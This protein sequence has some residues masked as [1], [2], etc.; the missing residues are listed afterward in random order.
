MIVCSKTVNGIQTVQFDSS[1]IKF[2]SYDAQRKILAVTFASNHSYNYFAVP[3]A[4]W[5]EM[6]NA[7]SVGKRFRVNITDLFDS[8]KVNA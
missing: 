3:A 6:K 5:S 4:K 7:E 8:Q 1:A 2:A